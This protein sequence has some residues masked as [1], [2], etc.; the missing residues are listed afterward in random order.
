MWQSD[1]YL[2]SLVKAVSSTNKLRP[3]LDTQLAS[4]LNKA[5]AGSV[6]MEKLCAS[7]HSALLLTTET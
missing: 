5:D 6:C 3:G 1:F 4:F 7:N 2:V